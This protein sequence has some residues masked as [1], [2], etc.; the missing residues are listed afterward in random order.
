MNR[1]GAI[2]AETTRAVS[3]RFVAIV[4]LAIVVFV[5][6]WPNALHF[7]FDTRAL[8]G[9]DA[10]Y[11]SGY[12][13]LRDVPWMRAIPKLFQGEVRFPMPSLALKAIGSAIPVTPGLVHGICVASIAVFAI[14]AF[15]LAARLGG[16]FAALA[17]GL[18]AATAPAVVAYGRQFFL[19]FHAHTLIL[20]A[21]VLALGEPRRDPPPWRRVAAGLLLGAAIATH[22]LAVATG[23]PVMVLL[24]HRAWRARNEKAARRWD[25][26]ALAFPIISAA[27]MARTLMY[28]GGAPFPKVPSEPGALPP[29]AVSVLQ[30]AAVALG[31]AIGIGIALLAVVLAATNRARA[32]N[33]SASRFTY[34]AAAWW[35]G[36]T[37]WTVAKGIGEPTNTFAY[38]VMVAA[39]AAVAEKRIR[40]FRRGSFALVAA[41]ALVGLVAADATIR[42]RGFLDVHPVVSA[43]PSAEGISRDLIVPHR[44]KIRTEPDLEEWA[45]RASRN[46]SGVM[47]YRVVGLPG[48]TTLDGDLVRASLK[49]HDVAELFGGDTLRLVGAHEAADAEVIVHYANAPR[50]GIGP[51][52]LGRALADL[53]CDTN[54]RDLKWRV[55]ST[56]YDAGDVFLPLEDEGGLSVAVLRRLRESN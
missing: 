1:P 6:I 28:R 43:R 26:A 53:R 17:T 13:A 55:N 45:A 3:P 35:L 34:F 24:V 20:T 46:E 14:A 40:E 38:V 29:F 50:R 23:A 4:S 32:R 49:I 12:T 8:T 22:P 11:L 36:L 18:F 41:V 10:Y 7:A 30:D 44:L 37:V 52:A 9:H 15:A 5:A 42:T 54:T 2:D 39:T 19:Q 56:P 51:K 47:R 21:F 33:L 48:R 16:S 27:F 31:P 25:I